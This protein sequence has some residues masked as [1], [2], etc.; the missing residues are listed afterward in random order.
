MYD[1]DDDDDEGKDDDDDDDG[2]SRCGERG[3]CFCLG[4]LL[5]IMFL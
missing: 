2:D 3:T 4:L 1:D 5:A